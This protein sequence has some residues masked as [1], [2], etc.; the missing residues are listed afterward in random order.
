MTSDQI[1]TAF[2]PSRPSIITVIAL[3]AQLIAA[4]AVSGEWFEDATHSSGIT[5]NGN[6]FGASWGDSNN[7]GWPDLWTSN[8]AVVAP[9]LYINNR[10]GTFT[11]STDTI[12]YNIADMH[13]SAWADFDNDGDQ[14]L[15][16]LVGADDRFGSE[17]NQFF[18]NSGN[19]F[20]EKALE[21]GL[22]YPLSR[23]RTPLWFD[24]NNDGRLDVLLSNLYRNVAPTALFSQDQVSFINSSLDTELDTVFNNNFAQLITVYHNYSPALAIHDY[25]YP[26]RIYDYLHTP[27]MNLSG[28]D[29]LFPSTIGYAQDAAVADFDGDL[30]PDVFL[31]RA[32]LTVSEVTQLDSNT[33][34]ASTVVRGKE[35]GFSFSGGSVLQ[36]QIE[37]AFRIA[38]EHIFIGSQAANPTSQTFMLS[39]TDSTVFGLPEHI[40][41]VDYG[42]FIGY[43]P[44]SQ[45]WL[46]LVSTRG[47]IK[48]NFLVTASDPVMNVEPIGF[49]NSYGGVT[50]KLFV[51]T[52]TGFRDVS[53][54]AGMNIE[55]PCE[56]VAAADFDNDMDVDLYMVCRSPAANRPNILYENLGDGTFQTVPE[57]GGAAGS[58]DG[59][60]EAVA[61]ADYDNDGFIDLLVTNGLE[62]PPFNDGP[63]QIFRNLGNA[64][65][66]LEIDL[67]GVKS[68]RDGIG[69]QI[70]ATTV[71]A[72]QYRLQGGG[73]HRYSQNHKRIHFGLGSHKMIDMLTVEWPSGT[74]QNITNLPADQIVHLLEPSYPML[75]GKPSYAPGIDAGL[76]LWK[77]SFDGPYHIEISGD[78]P[79][80]TFQVELIADSPLE[81]V[82]MKKSEFNDRL[83]WNANHFAFEGLVSN[84]VDRV[85]FQL[86][87]GSHA[88]L[89][90]AKNGESNPRQLHI[91]KS[92]DPLTPA[93]WI[94]EA[95]AIPGVPEFQG[96]ADL[97]LFFGRSSNEVHARW[98][99][100]GPQ[101]YTELEIFFSQPPIAVTPVSFEYNDRL[102]ATANSASISSFVS[103]WWDGVNLEI[104]VGT[105]LGLTYTQDGLVQPNR[106]NPVNRNLGL[107]NAYH[108]PLATPYG[109]P[110][111]D[112]STDANMFIWKDERTGHW[113]VKCTAGGE[114]ANY[115]GEL[116]SDQPFVEVVPYKLEA[117]DTLDFT[118]PTR[119]VFDMYMV[120][121]H[122]DGFEF[123][124]PAGA[125]VQLNLEPKGIDDPVGAIRIGNQ[126][127]PIEQLPVDISG[128]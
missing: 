69:A 118:D 89:S 47:R 8:H 124:V 97:G 34:A 66:W 62:Q 6:S 82:E 64:N 36:V 73:M 125:N 119:I 93:G 67:E 77:D 38:A 100:D 2:N 88:L 57:V 1:R 91:G 10:N 117:S 51:Q 95:D 75:L 101:H 46:F 87:P 55:S 12:P 17:P 92:G 60:G 3:L 11:E 50:D 99:G 44:S 20:H 32:N 112:S 86:A 40:P 65:H 59:R 49:E 58:T 61:L 52:E 90:V 109:A 13:G 28:T 23:G 4:G 27:F 81:R 110:V 122:E 79:L 42:I 21:L 106:V 105:R 78:G 113:H 123:V 102:V 30:H 16:V 70:F 45:L 108:L 33:V 53:N 126:R 56:N 104:A 7:D 35:L 24:W 48:T 98:N 41:G 68:N 76:F 85:D 9:S 127:W 26:G 84:W 103:N 115:T 121:T 31:A 29:D 63:T 111:Y 39:S 96:G 80:S 19:I 18:I 71:N 74:V 72:T 25:H 128:W 54:V 114:Y 120:K 94:L 37:P 15:L 5:F 43:D 22:D 116:I 14:D 107:P 83:D